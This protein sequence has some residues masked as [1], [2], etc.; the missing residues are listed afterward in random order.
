MSLPQESLD[1]MK[2]RYGQLAQQCLD[3]G[4]QEMAVKMAL[5][6]LSQKIQEAEASQPKEQADVSQ[7]AS[8]VSTN[9]A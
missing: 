2:A 5:I 3:L 4:I 7:D 6:Q 9:P 8:Q 1:Q